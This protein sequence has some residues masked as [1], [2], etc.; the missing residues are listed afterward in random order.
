MSKPSILPVRG[1][2]SRAGRCQRRR[3]R[4]A[5]RD[6]RSCASSSRLAS[7]RA[8]A[9]RRSVRRRPAR[10]CTGPGRRRLRRGGLRAAR[11]P[12]RGAAGQ[13]GRIVAEHRAG[14]QEPEHQCCHQ[15]CS[16]SRPASDG[17]GRHRY[18]L[19]LAATP[20]RPSECRAETGEEERD[21]ADHEAWL[22]AGKPAGRV[23]AGR[24][25]VASR[26]PVEGGEGRVGRR[27]ARC[28]WRAPRPCP[29]CRCRP[30]CGSAC[31]RPRT[32]PRT[33]AGRRCSAARRAGR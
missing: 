15:Q 8:W 21:E 7:R 2:G 26:S 17:S 12:A 11:L 24:I 27:R 16:E 13:R 32:Q 4:S 23:G 25:E 29:S 22:G 3:P 5:G 33:P 19:S 1:C 6:R 18:S 28:R 9:G 10:R 31:A 30:G 20:E 14:R